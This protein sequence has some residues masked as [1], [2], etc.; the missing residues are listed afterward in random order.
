[1]DGDLEP[2]LGLEVGYWPINGRTF[3]GRIG[4]RHR[5]GEYEAVP[6]TFGGAFYGDNIVLEY[7]LQPFDSGDPSHRFFMGWR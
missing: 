2:S 4:Y 7:A 5:S 6:V 1:M 3:V